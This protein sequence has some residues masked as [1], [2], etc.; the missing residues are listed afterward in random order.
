MQS[1]NNWGK[2]EKQFEINLMLAAEDEKQMEITKEQLKEKRVKPARRRRA[3][4]WMTYLQL[5]MIGTMIVGR[6]IEEARAARR[7]QT[8]TN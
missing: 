4:E 8:L 6:N 5:S 2:E 7:K 3:G 1:L